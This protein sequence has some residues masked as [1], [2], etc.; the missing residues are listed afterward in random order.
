MTDPLPVLAEKLP[1]PLIIERPDLAHPMR[2]ILA[3]TLTT[4][5]WIGWVAMWIPVAEV[6]A[7]RLGAPLVRFA[8]PGQKGALA[9]GQ[10]LDVFPLAMFLVLLLLFANG[11]IGWTFHR[12]SA[13]K[14]KRRVGMEQLAAS[15][16]LDASKLSAW[17]SGRILH[18]KHGPQG[19]VV[20]AQVIR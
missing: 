15:M 5:A 19:R 17:Q 9:L 1:R 6:L 7:N 20:D 11:L 13:P 2:R 3:L 10:L 8:N 14:K 4:L 18:V 16:A 12:N